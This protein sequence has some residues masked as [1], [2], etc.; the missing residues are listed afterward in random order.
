MA[1]PVPVII[2][3]ETRLKQVLQYLANPEVRIQAGIKTENTYLFAS[4]GNFYLFMLRTIYTEMKKFSWY[5][6]ASILK[7]HKGF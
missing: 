7:I 1:K 5:F 6:H 2:P 4:S 3:D